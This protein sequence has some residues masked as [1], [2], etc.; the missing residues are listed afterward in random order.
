MERPERS[1]NGPEFQS[2]V[3]LL[4]SPII[5]GVDFSRGG[6]VASESLQTVEIRLSF[7]AVLLGLGA[8]RVLD[9]VSTSKAQRPGPRDDQRHQQQT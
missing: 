4:R 6:I 1:V 8:V 2:A 9:V 3:D 5:Y 7:A